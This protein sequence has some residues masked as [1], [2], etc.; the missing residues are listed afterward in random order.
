[1]H[2]YI[3]VPKKNVTSR[4]GHTR[5]IKTTKKKTKKNDNYGIIFTQLLQCNTCRFF[6]YKVDKI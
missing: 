6:L 2:I 1:M 4:Y 5:E 3:Y